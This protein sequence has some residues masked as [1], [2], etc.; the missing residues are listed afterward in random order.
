MSWANS[1]RISERLASEAHAAARNKLADEARRLFI[2][3]A[4]FEEEA[5]KAIGQNKPRTLGIIA[6]SASALFYKGGQ[7]QRAEQLAH[8]MAAR[9]DLPDFAVQE[10]RALLQTVWN[11]KAQA[12]AGVAFAPEQVVVSVRG[13][14]VVTGGAPLDLI[15]S[16]VQDI[17]SIFYRTA[18]LLK[19]LPHRSKGP[20]S[21]EIQD[22]YKPWLFQ[23]VPGSYQFIVAVQKPDQRELFA[24]AD[25][26]PE[27][28]TE[29][30]LSIVKAGATDAKS[31]DQVVGDPNYRR[32]FL[33]LT[34]SLAPTGKTFE[35]IE[36]RAA[37]ERQGIVLSM[38]SRK[39]IREH[40]RPPNGT[41]EDPTEEVLSGVLR[42]VHLERDWLEIAGPDGTT[43]KVENVGEVV[44]D[45]IGPMVN[46]RVKVSAR[47]V[48]SSG[49]SKYSFLD[50]ESDE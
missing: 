13:G 5:L 36:L 2:R 35:S 6:V 15:V 40:L 43:I 45:V 44:D 32:T 49:P 41:P 28:L 18:E 9:S 39:Q 37:T 12:D 30:F 29:T 27:L 50:I 14:L 22:K 19:G 25:L 26:E 8:R 38:E 34:Q 31:L 17:Q 20:P 10:L 24:T 23:A 46:H 7:L 11:E 21:K 4:E 42:A 47:V 48:R 33:K 16:K 3:A 1:H